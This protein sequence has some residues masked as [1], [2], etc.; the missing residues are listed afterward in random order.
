MA[1][2]EIEN[3]ML[4]DGILTASK[5]NTTGTASST[6]VLKGDFSWGAGASSSGK[7]NTADSAPGTPVAGDVWYTGG[8]IYIAVDTANTTG[9][10]STG[11]NLT[12]K[13]YGAMGAGTV[14]AG[15]TAFG[16]DNSSA[17]TSTEEYNGN[18]WSAGGATGGT[19]TS[20]PGDGTQ[21][22]AWAG[23]GGT[24]PGYNTS[25]TY[26]GSTWSAANNLLTNRYLSGGLGTATAGLMIS[27]RVDGTSFSTSCEEFNGTCW[28][29]GGSM[30]TGRNEV[31]GAGILSSGLA[32]GG[33]NPGSTYYQSGE[34]YNGSAW[35]AGGTMSSVGRKGAAMAATNADGALYA[36]GGNDSGTQSA[37]DVYNGTTWS[38]APPLVR[39]TG[40]LPAG[41]GSK[42]AGA[43]VGGYGSGDALANT[44]EWN[45]VG[46]FNAKMVGYT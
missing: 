24:T 29:A 20:V 23:G 14:A 3:G 35:S 27:G 15:L 18:A 22:S 9:A 26:N 13:R 25:E 7:W 12:T 34:E 6:T 36:G 40:S 8:I 33:E 17:L 1:L 38:V 46:A 45:Y 32:Y 5:L 41:M 30:S 19:R 4:T 44:E 31:A 39:V 42:T 21:S 10:W 43:V 16:H 28:S 11:G 2:T 37:A